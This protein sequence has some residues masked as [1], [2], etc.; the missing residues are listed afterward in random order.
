ME[1]ESFENFELLA[2]LLVSE[3]S[4]G[5]NL[6]FKYPFTGAQ[7]NNTNLN[8]SN[9]NYTSNTINNVPILNQSLS[10]KKIFFQN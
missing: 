1:F 6:L 3:D 2:I 5:A 10:L 9:S 7:I 8:S 4:S